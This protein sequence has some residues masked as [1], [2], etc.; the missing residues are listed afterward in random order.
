VSLGLRMVNDPYF[1]NRLCKVNAHMCF[2][3]SMKEDKQ[4]GT[5]TGLHLP[6]HCEN[7][8]IHTLK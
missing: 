2:I 5:I 3:L 8:T 4:N 6:V 1:K 7:V